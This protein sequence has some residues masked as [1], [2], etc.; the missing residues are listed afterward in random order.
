MKEQTKFYIFSQRDWDMRGTKNIPFIKEIKTE[1]IAHINGTSDFSEKDTKF[2]EMWE[3]NEENHHSMCFYEYLGYSV[4]FVLLIKHH[5]V[6]Y[7]FFNLKSK[8]GVDYQHLHDNDLQC[9]C[10]PRYKYIGSWDCTR[11][12]YSTEDFVLFLNKNNVIDPRPNATLEENL[13]DDHFE[14]LRGRT[15]VNK[16]KNTDWT[17]ITYPYIPGGNHNDHISVMFKIK[18]D[19]VTFSDDGMVY[20][21]MAL[22]DYDDDGI[23]AQTE[24]TA[25]THGFTVS[26]ENHGIT[27]TARMAD[28]DE[29]LLRFYSMLWELVAPFSS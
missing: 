23:R 18:N 21:R 13:I 26:A 16:V 22:A 3:I 15:N 5:G 25:K 10:Y 11:H 6:F 27:A 24:K 7:P 1:D 12:R 19:E 4:G 2:L 14:F 17:E 9:E 20:Q 28:F 29:T 8:D